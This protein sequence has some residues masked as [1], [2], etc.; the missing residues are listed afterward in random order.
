VNLA[1]CLVDSNM[2]N[3]SSLSKENANVLDH[4]PA[5]TMLPL[6]WDKMFGQWVRENFRKELSD[7]GFTT[8]NFVDNVVIP[9]CQEKKCALADILPAYAT[10]LPTNLRRYVFFSHMWSTPINRTLTELMSSSFGTSLAFFDVACINQIEST[11][12][13]KLM[14]ETV[15]K[16]FRFLFLVDERGM[17]FTRVWCLFELLLAIESKNTNVEF[18]YP[19]A[20]EHAEITDWNKASR[21]QR[22]L[23]YENHINVFEEI[24]KRGVDVRRAQATVESDRVRILKWIE[25]KMGFQQ[26][27]NTIRKCMEGLI[28]QRKRCIE[29]ENWKTVRKSI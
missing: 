16:S 19:A 12:D 18:C 14:E 3:S 6:I 2:G 20:L 22:I 4:K 29:T 10:P 26:F 8:K 28:I 24:L 15:K 23:A 7:E 1:L 13:L 17:I 11:D 25:R 27:N 5:K 9:L 21:N